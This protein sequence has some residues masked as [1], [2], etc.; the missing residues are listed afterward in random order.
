MDAIYRGVFRNRI[1]KEHILKLVEHQKELN[2]EPGAEY[3][4]CNTGYTL[5]AEIVERVTG[6][7]FPDWAQENIFKPLGMNNTLFYDDHEKIVKNRAYSYQV[8]SESISGFK[9]RVLNYANVGATSLFTTAE[10]LSRWAINFENPRVGNLELFNQMEVRGVLNNND[11]LEYA[12]GQ[13]VGKYK[14]LK[15]IGHGGADAGY[16]SYLGRFP[17]QRFSVVILSNLASFSTYRMAMKIT[18]IYLADQIVEEKPKETGTEKTDQ[19]T[20]DPAILKEYTGSYE[21]MPG[22]VIQITLEDDRLMAQATGQS[23]I[24]LHSESESKFF[25]KEADAQ[26]SFQRDENGNV[27]Q[28][29][30]HQGGQDKIA[31]RSKP[32][33]L[34]VSQLDEFVGDY[35]S[36]ELGTTYSF[37]VEDSS[38]IVHHRKHEDFKLTPV[39][40]DFFSG[41]A[42]FFAQ[43]KVERDNENNVIGCRVSNGRVRNLEFDRQ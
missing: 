18:D 31:K 10:D 14:G 3:L 4:Y 8:A 7:P 16:R 5:M 33:A 38:L 34:G 25:I 9:K 12:F 36:D 37:V 24:Q 2:F 21:L 30:L 20:V 22:F 32:Y 27:N 17:E 39:R 41:S 19:V 40:E 26:V 23:K 35:Y 6:K 13:G 42:W 43:V 29:T 28:L 11:T 15:L 1:Y